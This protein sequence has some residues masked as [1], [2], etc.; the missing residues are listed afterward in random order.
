MGNGTLSERK[1]IGGGNCH[2]IFI[3]QRRIT[4]T[5]LGRFILLACL[6]FGVDVLG[7]NKTHFF[8]GLFLA[9]ASLHYILT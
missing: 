9:G 4:G 7:E 6:L 8:L 2:N 5:S 1:G 3:F